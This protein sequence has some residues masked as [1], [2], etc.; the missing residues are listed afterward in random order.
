MDEQAINKRL[1]ALEAKIDIVLDYVNRQRLTTQGLDDLTGDLTIIGKD[2][3]DTAVEEL[4]KRQ[5]EINPEEVTDLLIT[6]LRNIK[7]FKEVMNI[8]EMAFDLS[9]EVGPIFN[10]TIIDVTKKLA[11]FEEKGYFEF[12]QN[13][14][15]I[16]DK[17]VTGLNT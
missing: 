13:V 5:V 6:F 3:Y 11:E 17:I 14:V 8:L 10:E 7:N 1:D 15:P 16:I 4:D 9:K 12:I 2:F